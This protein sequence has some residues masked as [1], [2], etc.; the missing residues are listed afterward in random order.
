LHN[1]ANPVGTSLPPILAEPLIL[2]QKAINPK[3]YNPKPQNFGSDMFWWK[4]ES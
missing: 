1:G 2:F 3:N 4:S